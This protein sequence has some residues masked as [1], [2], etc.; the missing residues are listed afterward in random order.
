MNRA[1]F[2]VAAYAIGFVLLL[3][4]FGG[5]DAFAQT[6]TPSEHANVQDASVGSSTSGSETGIYEFR[7]VITGAI[8]VFIAI[9][10]FWGGWHIARRVIRGATR[11]T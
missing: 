3:G 6:F 5:E 8:G 2:W 11:S 1:L 4:G 7:A 9:A 10:I